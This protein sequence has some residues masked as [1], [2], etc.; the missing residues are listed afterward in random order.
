MERKEFKPDRVL[1]YFKAEWPVLLIVAISGLI[2]NVGLL[3]GPYFEGQMTGH[4]IDILNGKA[5]FRDM[6]CLVLIYVVTIAVVQISRYAKRFYVRRF[7]NNVNRRMKQILYGTLVRKSRAQLQEEGVGNVMTKA[8]LDVDDC[9]E[10]MRKFTTEIFDTGVALLAY[11]CML[12]WYDWRLALLCMIFPPVSYYLA[13]KMKVLIQRSG[14]AF[15]EQS[16]RLSTATLDRVSNAITYRV[17]GCEKERRS[18]YEENLTAYEKAAVKAN[19]WNAVLPPVYRVTAM[20]GVLFI[21]YFGGRNVLGIGWTTFDIAMFT[22][23]LSCFTRLSTKASGAAKLFNA[24]HKAQVSWKRICPLLKMPEESRAQEP[25]Q[26]RQ[27]QVEHLR[28]AYPQAKEII[29]DLSFTAHAGEI[30]GITGTVACGKSTLGKVFLCEYPYEGSIRFD[31]VELADMEPSKRAAIVG[32]LG[33]DPEL[34]NDTLE[35]N[36]LMGD[37]GDAGEYLR[38]VCLKEEADAMEDGLQTKI[39]SSGVRL[40]GGQAQ[41]LSLARTLCHKRPLL[42]LD[43]PFSALDRKT[44]QEIFKNL[45]KETENGIVLLISHRLYLFPKLSKVIWMEQ[46]NTVVA[47]HEEL[48][49]VVPEYRSLFE[50]QEGAKDEV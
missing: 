19:I 3:A 10:G 9:V 48:L 17:F 7:A 23:F 1:S 36:I 35:N 44:E 12:L 47:P 21:L 6:L 29:H 33:H 20:A 4:L 41:R 46:G 15:K 27:M 31:G 45:Q 40:S 42:I 25:A 34:M 13:E 14:A 24:V 8:I 32:Y 5:A 30:I 22:T 43:D 37:V 50:D 38:Q 18:A 2:Y 39:G 49:K 16:G 28:F 26:I 11:S